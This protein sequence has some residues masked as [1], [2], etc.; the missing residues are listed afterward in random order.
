MALYA[1]PVG[2]LSALA[3][4][5]AP[6]QPLLQRDQS[7]PLL[8]Q[9]ETRTVWHRPAAHT[10]WPACSSPYAIQ[11]T[12]PTIAAAWYQHF[13]RAPGKAIARGSSSEGGGILN[14]A[15]QMMLEFTGIASPISRKAG[16]YGEENAEKIS[17]QNFRDSS[18]GRKNWAVWKE[19][20]IATA[21]PNFIDTVSATMASSSSSSDSST[22]T[23]S[24]SDSTTTDNWSDIL[25]SDWRS[26]SSS[27]TSSRSEDEDDTDSMLGL[28]AAGYP[29]SDDEDSDSTSDTNSAFDSGDDTD[30]EDEWLD[31]IGN[32]F[33]PRTNY[34]MN[35]VRHTLEEMYIERYKMPR[36][37]FPR[38]PAFMRH[39]LG[40]MKD[41]QPDLF[42]QELRTRSRSRFANDSNNAQ[43]PV[44]DQLAIG[45]ASSI[46]KVTN[47]AGVEKGTVIL[48]TRR[49]MTAV[50]CPGFM[51]QFVCMPTASEKEK[52]KDWVESHS[53]KAWRN[54]WC[55]VDSTLV[56]LFDRPFHGIGFHFPRPRFSGIMRAGTAGP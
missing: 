19:E 17:V 33:R 2:C 10:A 20:L 27:S 5:H 7:L 1:P 22:T 46:Q 54:G 8:S 25:G 11:G 23:T 9:S 35:W 15:S 53:C 12:E 55:M 50:L 37:T 48:V 30:D 52:A 34:P 16:V 38:G 28:H 41:T 3:P 56:A 13:E 43:M 39:V 45:N 26:S 32:E 42:R 36:N 29:D 49:V 21:A 51:S 18:E 47:W 4:S 31:G 40:T 44:E 14:R 24:G 6:G